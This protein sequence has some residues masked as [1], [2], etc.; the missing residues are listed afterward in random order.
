MSKP[1]KES[2]RRVGDKIRTLERE[3][4]PKRQAIAESLNMERAGRL[5]KGGRY[6]RKNKRG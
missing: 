3:G 5:R 2:N 1:K 6:V 4:T